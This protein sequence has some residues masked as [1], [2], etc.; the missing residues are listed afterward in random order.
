MIGEA[1]SRLTREFQSRHSG[2]P[3]PAI[4]G[5]RNRRVHAYFD[6]DHQRPWDTAT[7]D[8]PEL[9]AR[10]KQILSDVRGCC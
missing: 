8:V 10:M 2:V 5:M 9:M 6:I 7:G 3:W 1:A 4:V